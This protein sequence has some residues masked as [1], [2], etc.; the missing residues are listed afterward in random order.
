MKMS[1]GTKYNN[2]SHLPYLLDEFGTPVASHAQKEAVELCHF[3]SVEAAVVR[4]MGDVV[5]RYNAGTFE[6]S[7]PDGL[8]I[9]LEH[10]ID[11]AQLQLRYD[12]MH[13]SKANTDQ[14]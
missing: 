1:G 8:I 12:K 3:A 5:S 14:N 4:D 2:A 11:R 6:D 13:P 7:V 9:P 10:A